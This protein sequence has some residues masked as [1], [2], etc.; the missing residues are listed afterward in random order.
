MDDLK[1]YSRRLGLKATGANGLMLKAERRDYDAPRQA[2]IAR[3]TVVTT[4]GYEDERKVTQALTL[5]ATAFRKGQITEEQAK[6]M[7]DRLPQFVSKK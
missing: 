6:A 2:P 5:I 1:F 7:V 4:G 3:S